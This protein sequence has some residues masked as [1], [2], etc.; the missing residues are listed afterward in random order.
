MCA[1]FLS[2]V[3]EDSLTFFSPP[4][5]LKLRKTNL[6]SLQTSWYTFCT[7]CHDE[8]FR[9][10]PMVTADVAYRSRILT[11]RFFETISSIRAVFT[12]VL[13]C[14]GPTVAVVVMNVGSFSNSASFYDALHTSVSRR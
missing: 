10:G 7:V 3:T 2:P 8:F 11:R 9:G 5:P 12:S 4:P 6:E 13:G 14:V 1:S